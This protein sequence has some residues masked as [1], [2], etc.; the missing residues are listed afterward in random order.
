MDEVDDGDET[1]MPSPGA[2][3][4]ISSEAELDARI[5]AAAA[6]GADAAAVGAVAAD[7]VAV[8]EAAADAEAAVAAATGELSS[9]ACEFVS[10]PSDSGSSKAES[11]RVS[12]LAW[13]AASRRS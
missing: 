6:D 5:A 3:V 9:G 13:S 4:A 7:G 11:S 12:D 1:R 8:D 10:W 2:S